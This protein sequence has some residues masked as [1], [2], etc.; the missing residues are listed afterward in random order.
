MDASKTLAISIEKGD[1]QARL[2]RS[3]SQNFII[4][5]QIPI[6]M[7]GKHQ[8]VKSLL[9]DEDIHQMITE[10]L[11]SVGCDV[12]V[13]G[14]KTYIEQEVF[15]S[16]GIER[17]KMISDNTARAWLK[18]F[19][20]EFR[21]ERKD[22]YYD[23]HERPDV[24]EYRQDF[25]NEILELEKWMSKPLDDNIMILEEP[26]LDV[27][28]KRH[29]L[30]THDESIFYAND[31]KKTY[32][33]PVGHQPLRKKEAGLSLHVSDFLTEVDGHLKFEEEEAC[34]MMKLGINRNG[35]WKTDDLIKQVY[36]IYGK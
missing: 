1:N 23:G 13:N 36:N 19:G 26:V 4:H 29:I 17:K 31:R 20:W 28:E 27:N 25:L 15:P 8:K 16:V 5:R 35:W 9:G 33:G 30:I 34:V 14:F 11:W 32:W 3:W 12:T 2:I 6:S 7:H 10:Y 21:V 22:V 24:I 18:H